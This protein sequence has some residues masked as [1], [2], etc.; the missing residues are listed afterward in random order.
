MSITNRLSSTRQSRGLSAADLAKRTG[1]TRQT[2]HAI[3]A[4]NYVPNTA[5]ALKL[6]R[7]LEV[8][9]EELF[10]L[11][12]SEGAVVKTVEV[13]VL[14]PAPEKAGRPLQLSKVGSQWIGV[15][16]T[17]SP[18][19]LPDSD[20]VGAPGRKARLL[21]DE[22]ELAKR[23]VL[24]GCDPALSLLSRVLQRTSGVEMVN[25]P[26]SSRLALDWLKQNRV[27]VAGTH[28]EDER[29]GEFNI[30]YLRDKFP[31]EDL[32]VV[33]FAS[34]E[35]GFVV[36]PGNPKKIREVADL[37]R[38][39][40]RFVNR[41]AGAGSRT[42]LDRL[43]RESGGD[44]TKVRGYESVA[45]GHLAAAQAVALG[46]ADGCLATSS[47]A[48]AFGLDFVAV[49]RERFDLVLRTESLDLP[50]VRA[51]LDILQRASLRRKLEALAGYETAR[52]GSLVDA[53]RRRPG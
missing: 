19:F 24:A 47:A 11:E 42:L 53:Q 15:P 4:G 36:A 6:A 43:I 9:V 32:T 33:T 23:L 21:S 12:E 7:E 40:V 17:P 25:A 52:T 31:G 44:K 3:E 45:Y 51:M 35:E 34:W 48:R 10:S 29:T 8:T 14:A 26:A 39:N 27:H 5:V 20:G 18:Y 16:S 38:K 46:E 41:E 49:R 50:P 28:L 13:A 1:V 22:Q 2:I 37:F 30:P